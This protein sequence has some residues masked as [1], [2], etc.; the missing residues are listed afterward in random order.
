MFIVF[1]LNI[2]LFRRTGPYTFVHINEVLLFK[3]HDVLDS[4]LVD[5]HVKDGSHA[6]PHGSPDSQLVDVQLRIQMEDTLIEDARLSHLSAGTQF[7]PK[8]S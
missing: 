1:S 6:A 8:V 3:H 7:D 4:I 5:M 2:F